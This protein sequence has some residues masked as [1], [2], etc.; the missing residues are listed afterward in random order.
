MGNL[1]NLRYQPEGIIYEDQVHQITN[2]EGT[3]HNKLK[4]YIFRPDG[5]KNN[6]HSGYLEI[7]L[8]IILEGISWEFEVFGR[9]FITFIFFLLIF[10]IFIAIFTTFRV[11]NKRTGAN[12]H[13]KVVAT[14]WPA[15]PNSMRIVRNTASKK[16]S[17]CK[18]CG[19]T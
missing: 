10:M 13:S 5:H 11:I 4:N 15:K 3:R 17:M 2:F 19:I 7:I 6:R 9:I 18:V 14:T 12:S 16:K 8:Y 1:Q